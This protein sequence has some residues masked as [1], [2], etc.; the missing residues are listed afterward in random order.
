[1]TLRSHNT[2][3]MQIEQKQTK[4]APS[5]YTDVELYDAEPH[6]GCSIVFFSMAVFIFFVLDQQVIRYHTENSR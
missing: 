1:M 2:K 3:E 4:M 5:F 6:I